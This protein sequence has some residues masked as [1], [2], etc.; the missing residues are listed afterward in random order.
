MKKLIPIIL[1]FALMSTA[2]A[3][4]EIQ[5]FYIAGKVMNKI[6][7]NYDVFQYMERAVLDDAQRSKLFEEAG[8]DYG[9]YKNL[10][11]KTTKSSFE[12]ALKALMYNKVL[13]HHATSGKDIREWKAFKIS[14]SDYYKQIEK[15]ESEVLKPLLDKR[16]GIV[17]SRDQFG[18]YLIKSNFPH[19]AGESNTDVY[20]RWYNDQKFRLKH[21]LRTSEAQRYEAVASL[22]HLREI[23]IRPFDANDFYKANK[24]LI[25]TNLNGKTM[26]RREVSTY[27]GSNPDLK[28]LI[29][30]I[31]YLSLN[32]AP[33][34]RILEEGDAKF[35]K[36]HKM[37]MA[38]IAPSLTEEKI[39]KI[40]GYEAL[41]TKMATKYKNADQLEAKSKTAMKAF[42]QSGQYK[43]AMKARIYDLAKAQVELEAS[44]EN[45]ES[46]LTTTLR[47]SFKNLAVT[48][49]S[50]A[51]YTSKE[52]EKLL[53]EDVVSYHLK[54]EFQGQLGA[55]YSGYTKSVLQ[56]SAWVLEFDA[57]KIAFNA[58]TEVSVSLKEFN[59]FD[60]FKKIQE[61]IKMKEFQK[62]RKKFR[63]RTLKRDVEGLF[64]INLDGD[65]ELY[66]AR[67]YQ[68][69]MAN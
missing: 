65:S 31:N 54:Q 32:T 26:T 34:S 47:T 27:L 21:Q 4:N 16:L 20:F 39:K 43:D 25:E 45:L 13:E 51:A 55:D 36:A 53:F 37:A 22:G 18:G 2:G 41:A 63:E 24:A 19:K 49:Q 1:L 35:E 56:L 38:G 7:T 69:L 57:K 60:T 30:D 58:E 14:S 52:V 42:M 64:S 44:R 8:G 10:V 15:L 61:H 17:K 12:S 59:D 33:L 40:L 3:A 9:Q 67:A 5:R 46:I 11:H 23:T 68:W 6:F 62:L 66:G 50:K 29:N 28:L 48:L